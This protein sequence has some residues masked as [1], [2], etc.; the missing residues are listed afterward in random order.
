MKFE[1]KISAVKGKGTAK[2]MN[3]SWKE[4][5]HTLT[6]C[7]KSLKFGLSSRLH[8]IRS[9]NWLVCGLLLFVLRK[10]NATNWHAN[11]ALIYLWIWPSINGLAWYCLPRCCLWG[12]FHTWLSNLSIFR[13]LFSSLSRNKHGFRHDMIP[14][15]QNKRFC[16]AQFLIL[17]CWVSD[18]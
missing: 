7:L 2:L 18:F 8:F 14:G 10:S 4:T 3:W 11:W 17:S 15:S 6:R 5:S 1:L 9:S 12:S 16:G 13:L